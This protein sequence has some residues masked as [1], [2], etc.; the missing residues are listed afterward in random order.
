MKSSD[1]YD[2]KEDTIADY[3]R[4]I[5]ERVK[6]IDPNCIMGWY[7]LTGPPLFTRNR[8]GQNWTKLGEHMDIAV[9]M[10]YP[11]LMG[12]RDDGRWWGFVANMAYKYTIINMKHRI[13]EYGKQAVLTVTNSVECNPEEM[14]KQMTTFDFGLGVA[15]FKYYGTTEAHWKA[16]KNFAEQQYGL[17]ALGL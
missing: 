3:G 9:P 1:W 10:L 4:R 14:I 7:S 16:L 6:S 8:L 2:F 5:C 11:Y 15:V 12:T 13:A 17:D